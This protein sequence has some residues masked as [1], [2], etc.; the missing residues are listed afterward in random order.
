MGSN[1]LI[2]A[3]DCKGAMPPA[4]SALAGAGSG[5]LIAIAAR[6]ASHTAQCEGLGDTAKPLIPVPGEHR[7]EPTTPTMPGWCPMF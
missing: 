6:C 4:N 7:L 2:V 3:N 1:P 5:S